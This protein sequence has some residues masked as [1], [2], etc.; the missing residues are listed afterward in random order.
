MGHEVLCHADPGGMSRDGGRIDA[1]PLSHDLEA[2]AHVAGIESTTDVVTPIHRPEDWAKLLRPSK[3]ACN[4]TLA[5]Q[6]DI[7]YLSSPV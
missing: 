5:V 3:R 1:S 7:Q 6:A 2:S 4:E